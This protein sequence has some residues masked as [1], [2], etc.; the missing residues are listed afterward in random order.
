[1]SVIWSPQALTDLAAIKTFIS[2][3]DP[4]AAQRVA[5]HIIDTIEA[6]LANNLHLGRPGRVPGT[7][8]FVVPKTPFI[9]PYRISGGRIHILRIYHNSRRWPEEF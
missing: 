7:R 9:I 6:L 8:E 5:F 2:E 1:M 4:M 3:N